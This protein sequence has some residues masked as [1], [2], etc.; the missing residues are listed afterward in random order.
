MFVQRGTH[1]LTAEHSCEAVASRSLD[2]GPQISAVTRHYRFVTVKN[3][4][5]VCQS[6]ES[7]EGEASADPLVM[8]GTRLTQRLRGSVAQRRPPGIFS[9]WWGNFL[10]A[11]DG[12]GVR[13]ALA[14]RKGS[15]DVGDAVES[16]FQRSILVDGSF[17]RKPFAD[18]G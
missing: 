6:I 8:I 16:R 12:F 4:G 14:S 10:G 2:S 9:V 17:Y 13:T 11:W 18:H 5:T 3:R 1:C 7:R 15:A